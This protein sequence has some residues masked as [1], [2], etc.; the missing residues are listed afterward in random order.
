SSGRKGK[1]DWAATRHSA[2]NRARGKRGWGYAKS[3]SSLRRWLIRRAN[4]VP[5]IKTKPASAVWS[6][7][8]SHRRSVSG[9]STRETLFYIV[10]NAG[11]RIRSSQ[12]LSGS[13]LSNFGPLLFDASESELKRHC[14]QTVESRPQQRCSNSHAI[15]CVRIRPNQSG[16]AL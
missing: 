9:G 2:S 14:Q 7:K 3:R 16:V 4:A 10:E 15:A 13:F 12:R 1:P 8:N 6:F 11:H 5:P